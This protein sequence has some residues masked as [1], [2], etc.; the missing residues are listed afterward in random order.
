MP[1]IATFVPLIRPYRQSMTTRSTNLLF[2]CSKN[3]WRSPTAEAIF[4]EYEGLETDS[5]GVDPSAEVVVC[6]DQLAWADIVFVM[7]SRHRRKLQRYAAVLGKTRV[8]CLDIPDDYDY[9]DPDL[10]LRLK[11]S[12]LP[13]LGRP[14][15]DD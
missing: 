1:E 4:A 10:V 7:E 6:A 12:V 11:R 2:I 13:I 15:E 3:Q 14:I 8:I 9:M 5:A